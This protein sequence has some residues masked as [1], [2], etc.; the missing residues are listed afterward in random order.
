MRENKK[1]G[2]RKEKQWGEWEGEDTRQTLVVVLLLR[3]VSEQA[4]Q[5]AD[6]GG[7]AWAAGCSADPASPQQMRQLV[8]CCQPEAAAGK[9][10]EPEP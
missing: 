4:L 3:T 9:D 10:S 7:A 5:P 2:E 1:E 6:L 8:C